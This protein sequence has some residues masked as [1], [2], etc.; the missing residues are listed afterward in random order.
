MWTS[1]SAL[2]VT[3]CNAGVFMHSAAA[4]L[5]APKLY[6]LPLVP[7][8]VFLFWIPVIR[9]PSLLHNFSSVVFCGFVCVCVCVCVWFV[10]YRLLFKF[11]FI[12][13][14]MSVPDICWG[15]R[16]FSSCSQ[17][18]LLSR[19]GVWA[20]HCGGFSWYGAPALW[21]LGS[22]VGVHGFSCSESCGIFP[23]QGSNPCPSIGRRI[24]NHWT[25]R[26]VSC[27]TFFIVNLA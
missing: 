24:L 20:S 21:F 14:F 11:L 27:I 4:K 16:A 15:T 9:T 12:F 10:L 8:S 25:T 7:T 2:S 19:C 17:W 3:K 23:H 6:L 18:E 1:T 5:A 26:E 22:V 13:L